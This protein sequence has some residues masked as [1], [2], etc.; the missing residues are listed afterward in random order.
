MP[1]VPGARKRNLTESLDFLVL[2]DIMIDAQY[3]SLPFEVE[4]IALGRM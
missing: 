3:A 4:R 2:I 1:R